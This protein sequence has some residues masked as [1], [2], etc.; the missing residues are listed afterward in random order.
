[1]AIPLDTTQALEIL[2]QLIRIRTV[3]PHGDEK[4]AVEYILSLFP[5]EHVEKLVVNHGENRASL[6]LIIPGKDSSR[7]VALSGHLDTI[8]VGDRSMWT[9]APFGAE[10]DGN[11]VYGRGAADM[12]GGLTSMILSARRWIDSGMT[13][14]TDILYC[15]TA[16][17]EVGGTGVKTL[18]GGGFLR[19]VEELIVVK[20]TNEKI[21]L[22]EKGALWLRFHVTGKSSHAAMPEQGSDTISTFFTLFEKIR[23]IFNGE[24]QHDLLGHSS[25]VLTSIKGMDMP[26]VVPE[27]VEAIMDVRTLP[28]VDHDNFLEKANKVI[29]R[30]RRA[31]LFQD[32]A[33]EVINNRP[34]VGM[35]LNSPLLKSLEKIY[36]ERSL[37]WKITGMNYFTDAS[38]LVPALGV[39]FAI[40][41]PGDEGFFHQPDEYVELDSVKR[42]AEILFD[43]TARHKA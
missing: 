8:T 18:L 33:M 21:G 27:R 10:V 41:G 42:V 2:R 20:P 3:Q 40:L 13:P 1:M 11:R 39:P 19:G 17:E 25:C 24:K 38:I 34:P 35:H 22:A 6:I 4:D 5:E 7:K 26:N 9:R 37:P 29:T 30:M 43:F 28:H 16:D 31:G 12:K 32:C 15:F 14:P 23:H 36:T